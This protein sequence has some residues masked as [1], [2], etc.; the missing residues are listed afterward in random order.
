MSRYM[1]NDISFI[2]IDKGICNQCKH[3]HDDGVTCDAFPGG[4][5]EEILTGDVSHKKPYKGDGGIHYI[6]Q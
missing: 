3:V 1:D 6:S 5:P 4:I 2:T